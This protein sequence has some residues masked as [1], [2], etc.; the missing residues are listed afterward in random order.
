M[1]LWLMGYESE[2]WRRVM[3]FGVDGEC[4]EVV[5]LKTCCFRT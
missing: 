1:D 2:S 3:K 4:V 5:T